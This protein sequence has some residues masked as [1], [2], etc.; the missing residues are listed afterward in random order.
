[1][2]TNTL[3]SGLLSAL[4]FTCAAWVAPVMA[5]GGSNVHLDDAHV[6]LKDEASLQ[7]GARNFVANCLSCHNAQFMRWGHLTQIGLTEEQIKT[8]LMPNPAAKMGD[9]MTSALDPKD[10]KDWFAGVPPDLTL[11]SR[12]RGSD[13]LYTFLRSYY[14]DPASPTGWN[15]EVFAN[16]SMPHILHELQGSQ[17]KLVVSERESHG[18]KVAVTKLA[19]ER[20]GTM[21]Q[22]E[23]DNYVRDLV[24][25]MTFM[26]EPARAKRTQLGVIVLLF[27][28]IAFFAAL[29]VKREY[30][31]DVK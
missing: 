14:V 11:V 30:W 27:L 21:T 3:R 18:K 10:A 1:M 23:Y 19:I 28:S 17:A 9:Y 26:G 13:W 7:R 15:N 29:L 20:Q 31:K 2:K 25:Y 8:S 16:T 24:N 22:M 4:L 12:S 5:A 6:N